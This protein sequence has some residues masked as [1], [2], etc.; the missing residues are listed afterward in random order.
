MNTITF[1]QVFYGHNGTG[2]GILGTS[3]PGWGP[4]VAAIC[5]AVGTPA[6]RE[7]QPFLISVPQSGCLIMIRACRGRVDSA[8]R[9]T[10][11]F[12]ALIASQKVVEQWGL[13]VFML[14]KKYRVF[15][16]TP[17]PDPQ[18]FTLQVSEKPVPEQGGN[19]KGSFAPIVFISS[20][21]ET[22]QVHS[23]A[24]EAVNYLKWAGF[25]FQPLPDFDLYALSD[26]AAVPHDRIVRDLSCKTLTAPAVFQKSLSV[27]SP[28]PAHEEREEKTEEEA[29]EL[30]KPEPEPEKEKKSNSLLIACEYLM[31]LISLGFNVFL[32]QNNRTLE[33]SNGELQRQLTS[34][35]G[36]A[37]ETTE[38]PPIISPLRKR[39]EREISSELVNFNRSV[40]ELKRLLKE[41]QQ[42]VTNEKDPAH[43]AGKDREVREY[44][45]QYLK[46]HLPQE[47]ELVCWDECKKKIQ[48]RVE[49]LKDIY[50]CGGL[51]DWAKENLYK[52]CDTR[53]E[54]W[55]NKCVTEIEMESDPW[56]IIDRYNKLRKEFPNGELDTHVDRHLCTILA[57]ASNVSELQNHLRTLHN[58]QLS[59]KWDIYVFRQAIENWKRTLTSREVTLNG[60]RLSWQPNAVELDINTSLPAEI[61]LYSQARPDSFNDGPYDNEAANS[62][63]EQGKQAREAVIS[64]RS[65][66]MQ[67]PLT[68]SVQ[69]DDSENF[70]ITIGNPKIGRHYLEKGNNVFYYPLKEKLELTIN[71]HLE[72]LTWEEIR[73]KYVGN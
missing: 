63:Y 69:C 59:R 37:E 13:N 52:V 1:Q 15:T 61:R 70:K 3:H 6:S 14:H 2:Y 25:S 9:K 22:E 29:F 50:P 44:I 64:S 32:L 5:E 68:F 17:V 18:P 7:F 60:E 16:D 20:T 39:S 27:S 62:G 45:H 58:L 28:S 41:Y 48:E 46:R 33:R 24:G 34:T 55:L 10:I 43:W 8:G 19:A 57:S 38:Q 71:Y 40:A 72:G 35:G 51:E 42:C 26:T 49:A 54:E 56:E 4:H 11:F 73:G 67:Q 53:K 47:N 31:L 65:S 21:E 66:S 36:N 23:F 30:P 12:H